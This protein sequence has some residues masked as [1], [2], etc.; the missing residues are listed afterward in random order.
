[1]IPT[2]N[3]NFVMIHGRNFSRCSEGYHEH[4][5]APS[6][7]TPNQTYL[8]NITNNQQAREIFR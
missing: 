5:A 2:C 6:E 4:A 8:K 3:D 7:S 1:M